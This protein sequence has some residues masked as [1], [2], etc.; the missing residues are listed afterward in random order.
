MIQIAKIEESRLGSQLELSPVQP[1]GCRC[2]YFRDEICAAP[3]IRF[4]ICKNCCRINQRSIVKNLFE[5][6]K[7]LAIF[8]LQSFGAASSG[9][10]SGIGGSGGSGGGGGAA[11]G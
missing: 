8:F 7:A 5:K 6:I 1:K 11:A 9:N 3:N 4:D 10:F 2:I